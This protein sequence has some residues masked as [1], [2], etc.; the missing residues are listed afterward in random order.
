MHWTIRWI[1]LYCRKYYIFIF[2]EFMN[3]EDTNFIFQIYPELDTLYP[4]NTEHMRRMVEEFLMAAFGQWPSFS[5]PQLLVPLQKLQK[6]NSFLNPIKENLEKEW[7]ARDRNAKYLCRFVPYTMWNIF[8][9][10]KNILH[11]HIRLNCGTNRGKSEGVVWK[12][13]PK[14]GPEGN[15][16]CL[17][18]AAPSESLMTQGTSRG[19]IFKTIPEDFPLFVRLWASRTEVYA[20]QSYPMGLSGETV[21]SYLHKSDSVKSRL[22]WLKNKF[23]TTSTLHYTTLHFTTV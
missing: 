6:T 12:N 4:S 17:R 18:G 23:W 8:I 10:K 22:W 13:L 1:D 19:Q 2:F 21:L 14:G 16:T 11:Y 9:T 7:K 20:A 3:F 5:P 15:Q